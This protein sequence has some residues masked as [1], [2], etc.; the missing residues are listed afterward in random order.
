[1]G[2]GPLGAVLVA[3]SE[4]EERLRGAPPHIGSVLTKRWAYSLETVQAHFRMEVTTCAIMDAVSAPDLSAELMAG[5]RESGAEKHV[6]FLLGAGASTT[7]GLPGWDQLV[8]RLLVDSG[9]VPD[10]AAADLLLQRQDPLMVAEA[11]RSANAS[12]W[13]DRVRAQLYRVLDP[14][15]S[16][17]LHLAVAGH[18]L[19]GGPADT[20]L[21]TLN[22]D[23]LLEQALAKE[24]DPATG[25]IGVRSASDGTEDANHLTVHHL[26]GLVTPSGSESV[27]FTLTDFL[28]VL[29]DHDSW[30]RMLLQEAMTRGALV[31]AG[32]SYR[33][34]DVRQWL[35]AARKQAPDDHAAMVIL[36][37]EGFALGREQF[38]AIEG[39]LRAQWEA[40]GLRPV[41]VDDH[42][43]AAQ[44]IRELRF[45]N[46]SDYLAPQQRAK[47][48]WDHHA[49]NFDRLQEQYVG[50]LEEDANRLRSVFG[51]DAL[52]VSLWLSDGAGRL[53]RWAADDR[54]F[55]SATAVRTISTGFDSPWIAGQA[56]SREELLIQ[57]I[58]REKTRRW[59]SV[60][61]AP[62]A[63]DHPRLP[64]MSTAVITVG[65]PDEARAY[66]SSSYL[67]TQ[68]LTEVINS[69]N[70]R[71]T[72][73]VF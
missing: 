9:T 28:D 3:G 70:A 39:A 60:A 42:S 43:D 27:I 25:V 1:M 62:V 21:V 7:S 37:R 67:W 45:V 4:S 31:I 69:W 13:L 57:D 10:E 61:A 59:K 11:A 51:V 19:T 47:R 50:H 66:D 8:I 5:F 49:V 64:T 41:L 36:A 56:L 40:V 34:P 20:S 30:Q 52:S 2:L 22:F 55:R 24:V 54:V 14:P 12:N 73:D 68:G 44:A 48:I 33:D 16:S 46:D 72:I 63:A 35:H 53:A 26:H 71:L 58:D 32:T 17:P 29:S 15:A 38:A 65:L 6:T 18:A 23:D